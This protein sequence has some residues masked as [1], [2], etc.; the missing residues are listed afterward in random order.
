MNVVASSPLNLLQQLLRF[1]SAQVAGA[2]DVPYFARV[3]YTELYAS[4]LFGGEVLAASTGSNCP[5]LDV[6]PI[7]QAWTSP[8]VDTPAI[9][10]PKMR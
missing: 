5:G 4:F 2:L 10:S 9:R 8:I 7:H 3:D 6:H 1:L